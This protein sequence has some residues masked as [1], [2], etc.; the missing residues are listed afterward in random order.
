MLIELAERIWAN[1]KFQAELTALV[2]AESDT[3]RLD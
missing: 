2:S 3:R 1:P